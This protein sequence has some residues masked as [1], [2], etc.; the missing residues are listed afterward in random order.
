MW[1][2]DHGRLGQFQG[3]SSANGG[4]G[5]RFWHSLQP[6]TFCSIPK[7]NPG[8]QINIRDSRFIRV[9]PGWATCSSLK[10]VTMACFG[11]EH[12]VSPKIATILHWQLIFP[13]CKWS[14]L[15]ILYWIWPTT[16]HKLSYS[17]INRIISGGRGV[18]CGGSGSGSLFI[19][20]AFPWAVV[21]I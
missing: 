21:N 17:S 1:R 2:H 8:H 13:G 10:H 15:Y 6:L 3:I 18:T 19:V 16:L 12:S 7:S 9:L 5:Q 4:L 20:S 11:N 14:E